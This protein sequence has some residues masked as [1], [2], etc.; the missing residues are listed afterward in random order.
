M[1]RVSRAVPG[2]E[3]DSGGV[4]AEAQQGKGFGRGGLGA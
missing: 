2:F 1:R 4:Y 3:I